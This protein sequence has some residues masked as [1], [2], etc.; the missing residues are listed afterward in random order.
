MHVFP[1]L[2]SF[3]FI[4]T[5]ILFRLLRIKKSTT[6]CYQ[7]LEFG[8]KSLRTFLRLVEVGTINVLGVFVCYC[9]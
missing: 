3:V 8:I 4:R 9:M 6:I 2:C 1:G 7:N 5:F